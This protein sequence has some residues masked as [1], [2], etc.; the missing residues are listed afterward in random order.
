MKKLSVLAASVAVALC[1]GAMAANAGVVPGIGAAAIVAVEE[2][3][4]S[5]VTQARWF[6]HHHHRHHRHY[7]YRYY[8]RRW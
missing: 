3:K 5:V 7:S 1:A 4:A 8:G 2:S 6:R